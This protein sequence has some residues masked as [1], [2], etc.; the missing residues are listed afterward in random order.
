MTNEIIMYRGDTKNISVTVTDDNNNPF[1][2]TNYEGRLTVKEKDTDEDSDAII[3]PLLGIINSPTNGV[4]NFSLTINDTDIEPKTYVYDIQ[5]NENT[6]NVFTIVKSTFTI[7]Q[8]VTG[9]TS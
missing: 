4:I 5:I 7:L 8:D 3:G 2:L 1:D 9:S 6:A